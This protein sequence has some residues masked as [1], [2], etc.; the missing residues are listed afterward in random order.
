MNSS[1]HVAATRAPGV[2]VLKHL[3]ER[4]FTTAVRRGF[5]LMRRVDD[6]LS[7]NARKRPRYRAARFR[8]LASN[9]VCRR[10]ACSRV[11]SRSPQCS[12][13]ARSNV[14]RRA[15]RER[16]RRPSRSA[17]EQHRVDA[18][19]EAGRGRTRR[20]RIGLATS[21]MTT[22]RTE[23]RRRAARIVPHADRHLTNRR[24]TPLGKPVAAASLSF[25]ATIVEQLD[26]ARRGMPFVSTSR[27]PACSVRF[28]RSIRGD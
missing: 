2:L 23:R 22:C 10:A 14:D 25:R 24:L 7:N 17:W 1:D 19:R 18:G 15:C 3:H 28:D 8:P 13:L 5:G 11:D 12:G 21:R 9:R 16:G 20:Q 26:A 4:G 6:L 27:T